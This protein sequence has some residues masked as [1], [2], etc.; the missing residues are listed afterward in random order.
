MLRPPASSGLPLV[1]A[2]RERLIPVPRSVRPLLFGCVSTIV[3]PPGQ[4][5]EAR[6]LLRPP[7]SS[8]L[9]IIPAWRERLI[10]VPR[11]VPSVA[12]RLRTD[13]RHPSRSSSGTCA[14]L[15][16]PASSGIPIIYAS[17]GRLIPL[18]SLRLVHRSSV[19]DRLSS[20]LPAALSAD[21][22]II[23]FR[24]LFSFLEPEDFRLLE[25]KRTWIYKFV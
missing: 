3:R 11:S 20:A 9:P 10:P 7:A 14:V 4:A 19:A 25:D 6:R 17:R 21:R 24:L 22:V 23:P 5:P 16:P 12:L 18:I 8:A 1:H 15:R 2:Y 13:Y